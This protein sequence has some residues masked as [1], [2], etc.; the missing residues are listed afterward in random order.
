MN[1]I[2][3][4]YGALRTIEMEG[5][6]LSGSFAFVYGCGALRCG[7]CGR[8]SPHRDQGPL[9]RLSHLYWKGRAVALIECP[10]CGKQV[11]DK[12]GSCPNCGCPIEDLSTSGQVRIQIPSTQQIQPGLVGA[13]SSKAAVVKSGSETLWSGKHGQTAVFDIDGPTKITITLGTWANPVV[14]TVKPRRRY[15]LVQDCGIHMKATYDLTEIDI[16]SGSQP[17]SGGGVGI[18]FGVVTEI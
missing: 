8:C 14:G 17:E 2:A 4:L 1:V 11:S 10:E 7:S 13:L 5:I 16:I 6:C 12:A 18:G 15:Q 9:P 3:H